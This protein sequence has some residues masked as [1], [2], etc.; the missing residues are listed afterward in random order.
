MRYKDITEGPYDPYRKK[1]IYLLGG[2]GSGKT[3]VSKKLLPF[4]MKKL[5]SD[6]FVEKMAKDAGVDLKVGVN[7]DDPNSPLFNFKKKASQLTKSQLSIYTIGDLGIVYDGTGR[8]YE[9]VE[10]MYSFFRE[11]G[12]KQYLI[13]VNTDIE[14][15]QSRNKQRARTLDSEIVNQLHKEV[16]NNIGKF[17]MLFGQDKTIILD[18][19][20]NSNPPWDSYWK[21]IQKW[22]N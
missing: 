16:R 6:V 18:N 12:Y 19:S 10:K 9:K 3:F 5:N 15:A 13:F 17:Q 2:P 4:G 22:V 7:Y 20:E 14:T 8:D 1:V 21:L 11:L